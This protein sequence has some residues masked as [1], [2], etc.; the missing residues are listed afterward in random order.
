[1][2]LYGGM[3]KGER[4]R[5]KTRVRS[6]DG[7]PGRDRGPLPRRPPALRLPARRRRPA[8]QPGQGGD[9][10]A[11]PPARPRSDRRA[12]RAAHLHRVRRRARACTSSPTGLNRDGIPSPSAHDPDR[13]RHRAAG[14]AS[15]PSRRSGRSSPTPAT[16]ASRCGTSSARTRC[17]STSTT[18]PSAT[19]PRCAGTTERPV[20]HVAA[21]RPT[22]R[23]SAASCSTPPKRMFDRNERADHAH[24]RRAGR[25]YVLAGPDALRRLRPT[26]A[27]P[28]EPRPRLLPLQ[29]HRGLP[30]GRRRAPAQRLRQGRRPPPRPRRAGSATLFD[31]DHLD[32]TCDAPRRRR[33]N[34]TPPTEQ[35]EAA[36]RAAIADCDRKLANYRALLDHEDAVTVA[37][38]WIADTQRERKTLE[39]QLGQQ[40]P[41]RPA[42]QPNR[43]RRSSKAL[44]DI[45]GVLADADPSDKTD[46]YDQLGI[47]L[48]YDPDGTVTVESRAPWGNTYVSEGGLEPP[49]PIRALGPQ[50]SA[51]AY[52]ATP[53]WWGIT[54]GPAPRPRQPASGREQQAQPDHGEASRPGRGRR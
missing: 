20:D 30:G 52:S 15:G 10:P 3:S 34:P 32:D 29:V 39:R 46:L 12:G 6:G 28:V 26:H 31:D 47:S 43:S 33:P 23:S 17:S 53:T 35:R 4:M 54:I 7:R 50:P 37:A 21:S 48:T 24:T 40:R 2:S 19:S 45:V 25:H 42:H 11:A 27:R 22:S 5:I 36:L 49:R 8:P 14:R 44:Q 38:S 1:M 16:P 41:R 51:S 9:R 18:S 13:N